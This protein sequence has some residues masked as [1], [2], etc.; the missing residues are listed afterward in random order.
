MAASRTDCEAISTRYQVCYLSG[1]NNTDIFKMRILATEIVIQCQQLLVAK[2]VGD[3]SVGI[4]GKSVAL[5][6]GFEAG[7]SHLSKL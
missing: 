6:L 1:G 4:V 7:L 3:V 2:F 5:E